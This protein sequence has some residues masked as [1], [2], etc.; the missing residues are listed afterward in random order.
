EDH[1]LVA[2]GG[3]NVGQ[4]P[5]STRVDV[6]IRG[7]GVLADD[8]SLVDLDA[9]SDEQLAAVLDAEQRV[10]HSFTG[11]IGDDRAVGSLGDVAKPR[12]V[13]IELAADDSLAAGDGEELV[14]KAD[15]APR[16]NSKLQAGSPRAER[17][18][19]RHSTLPGT[20]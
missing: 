12:R 15:Q 14:A 20:Q 4:L 8:H 11:A 5:P 7:V 18:H 19:F 16:G 3:A 10:G 17:R 6:Q 13:S 1:V 9:R 2:V